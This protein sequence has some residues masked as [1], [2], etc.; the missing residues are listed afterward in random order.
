ML[1]PNTPRIQLP[2]VFITGETRLPGVFTTGESGLSGVFIT[3]ESFWTL[4]S[5]YT[6]F[7]EHITIFK[8]TIILKIDCRLL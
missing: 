2:G 4:G 8:D 7:K 1:V 3:G 6:E 5:R